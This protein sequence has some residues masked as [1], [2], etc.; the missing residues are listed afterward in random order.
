V[1]GVPTK[2]STVLPTPPDD[3]SAPTL[4]H[5]ARQLRRIGKR[6]LMSAPFDSTEH[7]TLYKRTCKSNARV[8]A[9]CLQGR[10][11]TLVNDHTKE[12]YVPRV[13]ERMLMYFCG[14]DVVQRLL[15]KSQDTSDILEIP[16]LEAEGFSIA[17]IV[18]FMRRCCLPSTHQSSGDLRIPPNLGEGLDT[19]RACRVLGPTA[20]AARIESK[21]EFMY[22][23]HV[24]H[25]LTSYTYL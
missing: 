18:R 22:E 25:T 15:R 12:V 7:T 11:L 17:R 6:E 8:L 23:L 1:P 14:E 2:H 16:N 9:N 3:Y 13:P 10:T 5:S 19:I 21:Q 4:H 20:D 24:R